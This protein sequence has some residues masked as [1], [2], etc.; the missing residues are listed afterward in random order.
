MESMFKPV[1]WDK[2]PK[3]VR[4]GMTMMRIPLFNYLMVGAGNFFLKKML[5]RATV[6]AFTEEENAYYRAPYPTIKSRKPVRV[7]PTHIPKEGKPAYVYQAVSAYHNWLKESSLPK[8]LL[9]ADPGIMIQQAD[10]D[11]IVEHFPNT[12]AVHVGKGL[13]FIQEDHPHEIGEA[14]AD[15]YKTL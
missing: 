12:T 1:K 7:W 3:Q 13:H 8:L 15:W 11:W 10:A 4:V 2:L 14:I 9:H 5:P 6:R